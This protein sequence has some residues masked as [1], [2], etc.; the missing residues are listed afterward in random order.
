M[1]LINLEITNLPMVINLNPLCKNFY[2]SLGVNVSN[3]SLNCYRN[4]PF[5]T[6]LAY[7][8]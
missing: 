7:K 3:F 8:E 2:E 1:A 5:W 4:E 6:V